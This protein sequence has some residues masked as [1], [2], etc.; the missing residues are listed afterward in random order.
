[1]STNTSLFTATV[2]GRNLGSG[3]YFSDSV[4]YASIYCQPT[5][6]STKKYLGLWMVGI[7]L[8]DVR[9]RKNKKTRMRHAIGN[10]S[11]RP[12]FRRVEN[13]NFKEGPLIIEDAQ[14]DYEFAEYKVPRKEQA[15]MC[16]A[17]ELHFD[18]K[19]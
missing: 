8:Q 19:K 4:S 15:K 11:M 5:R 6:Q 9:V 18:Y 1:M 3:L 10:K 7:G 2:T 13:L 14:T 12:G 16:F 17:I